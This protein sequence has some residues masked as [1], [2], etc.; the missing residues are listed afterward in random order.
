MGCLRLRSSE[1][2]IPITAASAEYMNCFGS[3]RVLEGGLRD[4]YLSWSIICIGPCLLHPSH[5]AELSRPQ[6]TISF[7]SLPHFLLTRILNW[8]SEFD[9]YHCHYIYVP[10]RS[11]GF[12]RHWVCY[13]G[14][15]KG[16]E[17]GWFRWLDG[18]KEYWYSN[19]IGDLSTILVYRS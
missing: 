14:A 18:K 8:H 15:N 10:T 16:G 6:V 11:N 9:L 17:F 1:K 13:V 5:R 2:N 4:I 3:T 12:C 19:I 7:L